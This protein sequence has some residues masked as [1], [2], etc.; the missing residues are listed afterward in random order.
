MVC[1]VP[2][3]QVVDAP[4]SRLVTGQVTAPAVGSDTARLVIDVV[5]VLVTKKDQAIVSP[6]SVFPSP[7]TSVTAADLVNDS[8]G[9]W[10]TG[11]SVEDGFEG[12]LPP[13][14]FLPA[15]VAVFD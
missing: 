11:V 7:F 3:V 6:R 12:T 10:A 5:P 15:A 1:G 4:G 14:G 8:A 13:A 2:A 9:A